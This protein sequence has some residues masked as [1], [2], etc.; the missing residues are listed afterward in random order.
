MRHWKLRLTALLLAMC[1]LLTGCSFTEEFIE[2]MSIFGIATAYEDMEY[3]RPDMAK[4]QASLDNCTSLAQSADSA[5]TLMKAVYA[6]YDEYD[7]FYT[8]STLAQIHYSCD[9]TDTYWQEEYR[10]CSSQS[11][12]A[13]AAVEQ[14]L[15]T[16]A[17]SPLR[18]ELEKM[19]DWGKGFFDAYDTEPSI[20][21]T[22]RA[23]M[24]QETELINQYYTLDDR[25][26][27]A[28]YTLDDELFTDMA[29]LYIQL[30]AV[31]QE[32]ARYLGYP[33]YPT[34]AYEMYYARDYTPQA[35]AD[36]MTR[37]GEALYAPYTALSD[38]D[39]WDQAYGYCPESETYRYL[40]TAAQ[41]M[42]G[43]VADAFSYMNANGLYHIRYGEN[44]LNSSF[45]TY[46][47]NYYAPFVFMNP[48]LD[49]TDKLTFAHEFGHFAADFSCDGTFC[50]IDIA[51]TH[52]MAM[53][54][55]CLC[56][57]KD[58]EVLTRYKL[59]DSLC[60]YMEQSA[61]ALFEH[62]VYSLQGEDLT[63]E[64]ITEIYRQ[65]SKQF[66]FD[67]FD[68]DPREFVTV[69]HFFTDPMYTVSYVLSNDLAMQIYQLEQ[70]APGAGLS[71]YQKILPSQDSY[72]LTF[73]ET[74]GLESPF[75]QQRLQSVAAFFQSDPF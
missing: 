39:V 25:Y 2:K 73:A 61:Y 37:L 47:W 68:W 75:S 41:A 11:P 69:I 45:E 10:F 24:E 42:G 43:T 56:Y 65:V 51:E 34:L 57:S 8:N 52:S 60:T 36:Y 19:D 22:L 16:L 46:I 18:N 15:C 5:D 64:N 6:F 54:Y 33:D 40:Q 1:L 30:I 32:I 71:L 4:L 67:A 59:A 27:A 3:S 21:E 35:A 9:L 28:D 12:A 26:T 74:N 53:E 44:K 14:L 63:V 29:E 72:I 49:H 58:T 62:Q 50:G 31:R 23:L 13:E 70:E 17:A 20:D 38:S 48:Y 66:G 7:G 55:L